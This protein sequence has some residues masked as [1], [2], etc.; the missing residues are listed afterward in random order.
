M[1]YSP[2]DSSTIAVGKPIKKEL[3]D[4]V[5]GN[6]ADFNSRINNLET[7][8]V[9]VP[10]FKFFF[11]NAQVFSTATGLNYYEADASFTI[12]NASVRIFEVG[13]LSGF[14][15]FD[16]KRSVTDLDG[17][18]FVSIFTT[19]PKIDFSTA[20]DYSESI[21]QVFDVGQIDIEA[22]EF[23][24]L[25]ITQMPTSGVMS[26]FILNVYGEQQ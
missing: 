18:S 5:S 4:K 7:I 24:R 2:I 14:F 13:S 8:A 12:T 21:N 23:L 16:I 15:E 1:A 3:W 26:K 9:K 17:T 19:K 20:T 25:D 11:L 22:G 10:L 6:D